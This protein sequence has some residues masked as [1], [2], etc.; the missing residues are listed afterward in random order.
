MQEARTSARTRGTA[1]GFPISCG[2]L[3]PYVRRGIEKGIGCPWRTV[4]VLS[5]IKEYPVEAAV[6]RRQ[7]SGNVAAHDDATVAPATPDLF[8]PLVREEEYVI[9]RHWLPTVLLFKRENAFRA[10]YRGRQMF[11]GEVLGALQAPSE[12]TEELRWA[13][14][15]DLFDAYMV[16]TPVRRD[17]RDPLLLGRYEGQWY[18]IALWGESVL[19]LERITALVQQS[20]AIRERAAWRRTYLGLGGTL[21]GLALVLWLGYLVWTGQ[22]VAFGLWMTFLIFFFAWLPMLVYT[23][24]NVQHDFLD[25]Y[26]R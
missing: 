20:L 23:P 11:L 5:S 21:P 14:Q 19:P 6:Y 16:R 17:A 2:C 3:T 4:I 15:A 9:W 18:R 25:L 1:P 26:R 24:E 13:F 10:A 7:G 8:Y 22:P 12:V